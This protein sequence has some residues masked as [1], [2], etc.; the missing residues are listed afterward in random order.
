MARAHRLDELA[1]FSNGSVN[2]VVESP[3]GALAKLKYDPDLG[4]MTLVRP[5]PHGIVFPFDFG[6]VP[7][8]RADDGDPLDAVVLLDAPTFP[9]VVIPTRVVA[10]LRASQ[11]GSRGR[12]VR[13]DRLVCIADADAGKADIADVDGLPARFREELEGFFAAAVALEDK[14]LELLGWGGAEE[15]YAAI[16]EARVRLRKS[17]AA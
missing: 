9:G 2:V 10:V 8:T 12:R 1:T 16:D 5:L 3:R 13:N 15:A 4:A 14:E 17:P 7:Q 11:R 6:F